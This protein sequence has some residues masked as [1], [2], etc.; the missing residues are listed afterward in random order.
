MITPQ[1]HN[2]KVMEL[3][4]SRCQESETI[5]RILLSGDDHCALSGK[6]IG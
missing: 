5:H 3:D 2:D 6:L 4:N 1:L